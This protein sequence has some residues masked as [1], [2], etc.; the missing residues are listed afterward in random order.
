VN[1][2][3]LTWGIWERSG[4]FSW[5]GFLSSIT[6][7]PCLLLFPHTTSLLGTRFEVVVN[8]AS[9]GEGAFDVQQTAA[10]PA[11]KFV[12]RIG[13]LI[14]AEMRKVETALAQVLGLKLA[15]DPQ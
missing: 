14:P 12:R 1:S 6:S 3:S 5:W 11:I 9:L 4:L 13:S 7:A 15:V 8:H 2:G 10:V